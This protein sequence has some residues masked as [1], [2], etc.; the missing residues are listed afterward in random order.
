MKAADNKF[1]ITRERDETSAS[2]V[3][4][5]YFSWLPDRT[6][7]HG[8][9]M[10]P[11]IGFGMRNESPAALIGGAL[12]YNWNLGFVAGIGMLQEKR[13]AGKYSEN[14]ILTENL[15]D[16]QLHEKVWRPSLFVAGTVRFG[17]NPFAG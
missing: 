2:L 1:T 6:D 7:W 12:N 4:S 13:L 9:T 3:P 10:S 11:T 15:N 5:V 16:D 8:W 14:Q 17:S